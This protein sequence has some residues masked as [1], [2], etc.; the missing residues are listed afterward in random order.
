MGPGDRRRDRHP[1]EGHQL[2]ILAITLSPDGKQ[3][4]SS[5]D[6]EGRVLIWNLE[7]KEA[8][9]SLQ[10]G[11]GLIVSLLFSPDNQTLG[12]GGFNGVIKLFPLGNLA[13]VPC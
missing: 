9:N 8:V 6:E 2:Q 12:V 10:I 3:L 5:S 7:S 4:I 13:T 1:R 11:Q